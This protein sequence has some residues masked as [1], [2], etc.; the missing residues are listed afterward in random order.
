MTLNEFLTHSY[1]YF[2]KDTEKAH[3]M[4]FPELPDPMQLIQDKD[5]RLECFVEYDSHI[6]YGY[7]TAPKVFQIHKQFNLKELEAFFY[8]NKLDTS[9][10]DKDYLEQARARAWAYFNTLQVERFQEDTQEILEGIV[11]IR[12]YFDDNS[13][14]MSQ[15]L[16]A[17]TG[18]LIREV[19]YIKGQFFDEENNRP[20]SYLKSFY[21]YQDGKEVYADLRKNNKGVKNWYIT[22]PTQLAG[23]TLESIYLNRIY[24]A[25]NTKRHNK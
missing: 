19:R 22:F 16:N 8:E 6:N 17:D 1:K 25:R 13:L 23:T 10:I 3:Y 21:K 7:W 11:N 18:E 24:H 9:M 15:H 14:E 5:S 4:K 20:V 2:V 12:T